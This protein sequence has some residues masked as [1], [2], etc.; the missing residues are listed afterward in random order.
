MGVSVQ[1]LKFIISVVRDK[2][3]INITSNNMLKNNSIY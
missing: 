3:L 2:L 1:F